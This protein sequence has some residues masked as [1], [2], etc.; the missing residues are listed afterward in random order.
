MR[1]RIPRKAMP[2]SS[3]FWDR[4]ADRYARKPVSDQAVYQEKLRI[5]REHLLAEMRVLEFGCGSGTTALLHAPFIRQ[6]HAIDSS[7]RMIEIARGKAAEAGVANATF[8][9][10][11][12]EEFAARDE[13]FDAI[14][15]LSVLH[16]LDDWRSVVRKVHRLLNPGGVFV[17]STPCPGARYALLKLFLPI[18]SS[19]GLVPSVQFFS[20]DE[21]LSTM[22]DAGF[23]LEHKWNPADGRTAFIVAKK[24]G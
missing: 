2:T 23:T 22:R 1:G 12:I 11:S 24:A 8:E 6:I 14:L 10:A 3:R 15:G 7:A 19:L 5:A 17:S 16:L 18:G 9:Q 13:R 4:I 20:E 21:L